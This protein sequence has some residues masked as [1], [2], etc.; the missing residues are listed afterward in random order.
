MGI[1]PSTLVMKAVDDVP[2]PSIKGGGVKEPNVLVPFNEPIYPGFKHP[3]VLLIL[4]DNI[5]F[6]SELIL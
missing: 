6:L 4:K 2:S 1:D 5:V 3:K